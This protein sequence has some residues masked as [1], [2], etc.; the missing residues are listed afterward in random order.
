MSRFRGERPIVNNLEI[1]EP[2][3]ASFA[4]VNDILGGRV[5]MRPAAVELVAPKLMR[6]PKFGSRGFQH[7]LGQ[8]ALVQM[9]PQTFPGQLIEVHRSVARSGSAK[10]IAVE[11]SKAARF[12]VLPLFGLA[13]EANGYAGHAKIQ[14]CDI[15]QLF[16]VNIA[17][18][19]HDVLAPTDLLGDRIDP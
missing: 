2:G 5:T 15:R 11:H 8:R 9:F 10:T 3:P 14:I 13:P 12:P 16:A 17:A 1:D 7:P 6:A 19:D 18:F 4:V